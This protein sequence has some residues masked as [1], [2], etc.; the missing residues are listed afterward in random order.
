MLNP[1]KVECF[2]PRLH[3]NPAPCH[4]EAV[5][6][7]A[8]RRTPNEGPLHLACL[9]GAAR[10]SMDPSSRTKRGPQDDNTA[11][12]AEKNVEFTKKSFMEKYRP[13]AFHQ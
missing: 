2:Y 4:P 7:S 10:E 9:T 8:K 1:G 12:D 6:P 5:E 13:E 3:S 11:K